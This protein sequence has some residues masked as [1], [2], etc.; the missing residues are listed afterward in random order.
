MIR[1]LADAVRE[2][3]NIVAL[4][5]AGMS[6]ESDIAPFRGKGGLWEKF[7]PEEYAH[8]ESFR[9]NPLRSWE[10]FKLQIQEIVDAE[11]HPGYHALV[12]LESH[13]L[14]SII[15]Q[16]IDGLHSKAGSQEVIELHGTLFKLRCGDCGG[17]RDTSD[18]LSSIKKGKV[19]CC[20]CGAYLRPDVV[21]F[22]EPLPGLKWRGLWS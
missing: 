2:A 20:E 4:T 21:M 3:D 14:R 22:G 16:N 15:T 17:K 8:I 19:P 18:H 6:V 9:M 1:E 7:D 5:G 10:L 13:G 11:P 12:E